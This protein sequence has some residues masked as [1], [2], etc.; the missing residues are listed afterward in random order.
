[1]DTILTTEKELLEKIEGNILLISGQV[2][3]KNIEPDIAH[4]QLNTLSETVTAI[5]D[6]LEKNNVNYQQNKS[7]TLRLNV[8]RSHLANA[9]EYT[10]ELCNKLIKEK[11]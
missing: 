3:V 11:R 8:V 9:I 6:Q 10:K 4:C 5:V 2:V 1:M 7:F